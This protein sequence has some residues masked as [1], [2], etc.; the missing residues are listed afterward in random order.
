MCEH[1][2]SITSAS[3]HPLCYWHMTLVT[4]T[5]I[6]TMTNNHHDTNSLSLL[7]PGS[8]SFPHGC[9]CHYVTRL[10]ISFTSTCKVSTYLCVIMPYVVFVPYVKETQVLPSSSSEALFHMTCGSILVSLGLEMGSE[11]VR[12]RKKK[13]LLCLQMLPD[14]KT[15]F[16][17]LFFLTL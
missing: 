3:E 14:K 10:S 7:V 13:N 12:E 4:Q 2:Q 16:S 8:L 9:T 5:L 6:I 17:F 1:V 15:L 11:S